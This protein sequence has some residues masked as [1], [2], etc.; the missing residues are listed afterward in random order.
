M[1]CRQLMI[2]TLK[3]RAWKLRH[4]IRGDAVTSLLKN[5]LEFCQ[6]FGSRAF[7]DYFPDEGHINLLRE[8]KKTWNPVR[9]AKQSPSSWHV[10]GDDAENLLLLLPVLATIMENVAKY[11]AG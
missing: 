9:K 5:L 6:E 3:F 2:Q 10:M 1:S 4:G 7:K 11:A 8:H